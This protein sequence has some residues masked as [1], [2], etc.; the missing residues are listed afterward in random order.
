VPHEAS[1]SCFLLSLFLA[2]HPCCSAGK[3][4]YEVDRAVDAGSV[5]GFIET[6]GTIGVLGTS[7]VL[8]WSLLL[9]DGTTAFD[10]LGH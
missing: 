3:R 9:N 8:D 6:D 1:F 2:L 5:T 10:L 4:T 7:N